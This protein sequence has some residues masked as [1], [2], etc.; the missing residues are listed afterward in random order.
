MPPAILTKNLRREFQKKGKT[1]HV[2]LD[3]VDIEVEPGEIFGFLGPNGAGKTT[4]IKILCTLLYPSGGEAYVDGLDVV[5]DTREV[6][7][8]IAIVSGGEQSGYGIMTVFENIWMFSQFYG[9]PS[10][11]A[12][13]RIWHY[14]KAFGLEKDAHT[15]VSKLSTGMRQKMNIIRGFVTDPKIFFLDEPTLG[16]DVHI[17]REVR[18][19][20][21]NW[22][23][24]HPDKTVFLTTHYMA[25][26]EALCDRI[27]IIDGG[28]IVECDTPANIREKVGGGAVYHLKLEPVPPD[29][30]FL[31]AIPA[32]R[33]PVL[34]DA[35]EATGQCEVRFNLDSDDQLS[36]VLQAAET[37][38]FRVAGFAKAEPALEDLFMT[39]VGRKLRDEE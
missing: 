36:H 2:A 10:K 33:N 23:T 30:S 5:K 22:T 19:T 31:D 7:R 9:I 25:E 21:R 26:A 17:A 39:I 14:L 4:L 15:K 20:I 37:R 3:G 34:A 1:K 38:G 27:A 11:I 13:D 29:L 8:R 24:D 32:V 35:N 16:L 18:D 28:K 12:K 6:R